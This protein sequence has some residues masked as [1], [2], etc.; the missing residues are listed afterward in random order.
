M[1]TLCTTSL[2]SSNLVD[3]ICAETAKDHQLSLE[4]ELAQNTKLVTTIIP[5]NIKV[6]LIQSDTRTTCIFPTY[7]NTITECRIS[8]HY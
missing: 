5:E 7:P 1:R 4:K 2:G 6:R 8:S 3:E